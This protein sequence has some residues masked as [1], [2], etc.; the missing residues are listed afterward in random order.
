MNRLIQN[1]I[2]NKLA[3]LILR[4]Q[5]QDNESVVVTRGEK[6]LEV[7]ANHEADMSDVMDVDED[8]QDELIEDENDSIY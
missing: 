3:I 6:G 4:G 1:E 7:H 2:L 5:V 8:E